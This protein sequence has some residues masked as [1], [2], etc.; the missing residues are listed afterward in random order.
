MKAELQSEPL[1]CWEHFP[2][3]ISIFYRPIKNANTGCQMRRRKMENTKSNVKRRANVKLAM[4]LTWANASYFDHWHNR[5]RG[6]S[7]CWNIWLVIKLPYNAQDTHIHT[8]TLILYMYIYISCYII[9]FNSNVLF[10]GHIDL[11]L[12][13]SVW[14]K[15]N[16][17]YICEKIA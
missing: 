16:K 3:S 12:C 14:G 11:S 15:Q 8:H 6:D 4:H 2:Y 1:T 5:T 10:V 7:T 13:T 9:I 17:K